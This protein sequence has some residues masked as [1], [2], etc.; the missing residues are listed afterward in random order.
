[1]NK[2]E[3]IIEIRDG[4][5]QDDENVIDVIF[6]I[7]QEYNKR[8]G[9]HPSKILISPSLK[10]FMFW[11]EIEGRI[12]SFADKSGKVFMLFDV[13]IEEAVIEI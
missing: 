9:S 7:I 11:Q 2:I 5:I 1:M 6:E 4:D 3:R 12:G 10:S 13:P 8:E